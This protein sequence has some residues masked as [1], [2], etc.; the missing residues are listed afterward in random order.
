[1]IKRIKDYLTIEE[2][3]ELN[4]IYK[5]VETWLTESETDTF[6]ATYLRNVKES[7]FLLLNGYDNGESADLDHLILDLYSN[8]HTSLLFYTQKNKSRVDRLQRHYYNIIKLYNR[9]IGS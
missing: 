1:M 5:F 4:K 2:I 6:E 7:V 8:I 9:I 3:T